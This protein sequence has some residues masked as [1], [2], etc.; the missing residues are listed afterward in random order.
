MVGMVPNF[1]HKEAKLVRFQ[2]LAQG[3][4]CRFSPSKRKSTKVRES[5]GKTFPCHG[6]DEEFDSPTDRTEVG[7]R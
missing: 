6:I 3:T 7:C 1:F 4:F 2:N 5:G